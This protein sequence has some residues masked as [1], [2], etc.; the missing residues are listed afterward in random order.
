MP[1]KYATVD[2]TEEGLREGMQIEDRDIPA[3][4]K[5]RLL[6][7]LSETGLKNIIIGSFVS[8]RYTPQMRNVEDVAAGFTPKAGVRYSA[9][10]PND[11][12]RERAA[13][14]AGK[15][16]GLGQ[17]APRASLG[18]HLCDVF[19]RRNWNRSQ[20]DEIARWPS[21][22]EAAKQRDV[23]EAG[24]GMNAA[25]GSNFVGPFS[26]EL[27]MQWLTRQHEMWDEAG[28][29]VT[30][31]SLGD[32]M[33]WCMPH[34]VE[35][36][37]VAIKHKWPEIK[38]WSLHLHNGRGM[39]LPS[40]YAALRVLDEDEY[41]HIDTSIGGIGGCPYCGNGRATG[42]APTEDVICM[43]E[44]MGI[45]TGV[46]LKKLIEC[47]W[48]L[49]EILGRSTMGHVSKTGWLPRGADLYDMNMPFVETHEEA[50]HFIKG[51]SV[52]EGQ[53]N[54]WDKPIES[55]QRAAVDRQLAEAQKQ[56]VPT[57]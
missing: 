21:I 38:R 52:Y 23:K 15:L 40:T 41:L 13:P 12:G 49:E 56:P 1:R 54:P 31:C 29:K 10:I 14:F 50:K 34:V 22:V 33:S 11:R 39:A 24:I 30:S 43:L 57:S 36:Q 45:D 6:D 8:P 2:I 37:I 53:V 27:R 26:P 44:E 25:W 17:G 48:L 16:T 35:E 18:F 32:P 4:A 9:L 3:E 42:M 47:V 5:I 51:P 19:T 28:I 46:D 7:A 55:E 20:A